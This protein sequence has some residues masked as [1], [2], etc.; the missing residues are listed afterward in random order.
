MDNST[1]ET[2]V[3]Q[4][5]RSPPRRRRSTFFERRDSI[6]PNIIS[7]KK[8]EIEVNER[9]TDDMMR[10]YQKLLSE[11]EMWKKETNEMRH[12]YDDIKQQYKTTK[13]CSGSTMSFAALTDE[14]IKFFKS[15]LNVTKLIDSQQ[16]LHK[17]VLETRELYRRASE[18][19][20]VILTNSEN[21]VKIVTD[22]ILE[23]S[24]IDPVD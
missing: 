12:K 13:S 17:C 21:R 24:T 3:H 18:L 5:F 4:S 6:V 2:E 9:H 16:K 14:D 15:K 11:Q 1:S 20:N 10:Y 8:K 7:E 19:D 23:N 22:Y